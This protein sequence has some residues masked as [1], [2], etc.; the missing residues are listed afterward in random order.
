MPVYS[1]LNRGNGFGN[2]Y[3]NGMQGGQSNAWGNGYDAFGM[4]QTMPAQP[5]PQTAQTAMPNAEPGDIR[6]FVNGR[7][8]A[9]VYPMPQGV[10]VLTL[11][12]VSGKRLYIKAYDNNGFPRVIDDLDV[13]PHVEPDP[14]KYVTKDDIRDILD[15]LLGAYNFPDMKNFV[16][17]NEMN[18]ALSRT[19]GER[20]KGDEE[21]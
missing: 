17:R 12:D 13:T 14:P 9:D 21:R 3:G 2:G 1:N 15:E 7:A 19:N 6:L 11:W 5:Q 20:R 10:H 18:K 4:Q 16:T 8:A